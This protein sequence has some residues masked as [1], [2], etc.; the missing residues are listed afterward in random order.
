MFKLSVNF[1]YHS[2][3]IRFQPE[4]VDVPTG[5]EAA[6]RRAFQSN[7]FDRLAAAHL[8]PHSLMEAAEMLNTGRNGSEA[9]AESFEKYVR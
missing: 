9:R 7:S 2:D 3:T 1:Y 6:A 8:S 5:V 4:D